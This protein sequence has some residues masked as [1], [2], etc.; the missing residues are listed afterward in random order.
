MKQQEWMLRPLVKALCAAG[1]TMLTG[2]VFAGDTA[3]L[4]EVEV[5]APSDEQPRNT[6]D[7]SSNDSRAATKTTTPLNEIAQSVSVIT[8]AQIE[9]Q[10]PQTIVQALNYSPGA[11][12][13]LFGNAS[14]YDYV[15]LRGFTDTSMANTVLDG[16]RL[17]SDAGSFSAFQIDPFFIERVDFVR[18]P[19]S[20]L[21]GNAAPGGMVALISKKPQMERYNEVRVD[22]G[23]DKE[24]ALAF[25]FTGP[26]S[27][28]LSYRLTGIGRAADSM[29][30]YSKEERLALMPQLMWKP[31]ADTTLLLQAYLQNDPKGG[32]HSGTPFE[33][34]VI[35]HAGRKVS[36]EF[37]DGEPDND[38]FDREQRMIGYQFAHRF[39]P[40]WQVRQN[41][42]YTK[43]DINLEQVYQSGWIDETNLSRGYSFSKEKLDGLAV[44]TRVQG[45][46]TTGALMHDVVFGIDYQTR[47]NKGFWGWGSVGEINA[48][49]PVYGQHSIT[50]KG[51][52]N[53][54]REFRQLG[55]YLQ[56]QISIGGWRLTGGVRY[57]RARTSSLDTDTQVSTDWKGSETSTRLGALYLFDNGLAPYLSYSESFD[58]SSNTDQNGQVLR[59]TRGKQWEA[60]LKYQPQA[61]TLFT[62]AVYDLDQTNLARMVAGQ[63]Y[64]EPVGAVNSRGVELESH[65]GIT[66]NVHLMASYTYN[67]MSLENGVPNED[68]NRP[69]QSPSQLASAWVNYTPVTGARIGGGVRYI[70]K[71]YADLVNT[72]T[73]PG[74]TLVDLSASA[75]L[76]IWWSQMKG[77]SVQI[78]VQNLFDKDYVASCY[79]EKYCYFGNA[80]SITTSLKYAW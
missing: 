41:L 50:D 58:P 5:V 45:V 74:V 12:T 37:F 31:S 17:M 60:G 32:Y 72:L 2:A 24:R 55:Y 26:L 80:R 4:A 51:Q 30:D 59:P 48:F 61:N 54:T 65:F 14:R 69:R 13:G 57:D 15:A 39:Q 49:D 27:E 23:T 52:S 40:E 28:T 47:E 79:D 7:W 8:Q 44:D 62:A 34:S 16:L 68:G 6:G 73:V 33:G 56:D 20:V 66:D 38:K 29:Q 70:G 53:W 21:Y 9:A 18:G 35:E 10:M 19:M 78:N 25:D 64:F 71:S 3:L 22:L 76:G 36:R 75:D 77:A 63:S 43:S 46:F 1:M 67:K 42:R 11:F